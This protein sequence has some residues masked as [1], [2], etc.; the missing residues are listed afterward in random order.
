MADPTMKEYDPNNME[1]IMPFDMKKVLYAGFKP[2]VKK[3]R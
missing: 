1:K 3:K 2:L